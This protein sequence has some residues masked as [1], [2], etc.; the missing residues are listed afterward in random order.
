MGLVEGQDRSFDAGGAEEAAGGP[1]D[2]AGVKE[3]G[4][5]ENFSGLVLLRPVAGG[6][7]VFVGAGAGA[8][9]SGDRVGGDAFGGEHGGHEV[10]L[11]FLEFQ[12]DSDIGLDLDDEDVCGVAAIVKFGG[13]ER[14]PAEAAPED[15]DRVGILELVI[16]DPGAGQSGEERGAEIPGG[17]TASEAQENK[18]QKNLAAPA[19]FLWVIV[20]QGYRYGRTAAKCEVRGTRSNVRSNVKNEARNSRFGFSLFPL[21]SPVKKSFPAPRGTRARCRTWSLR[22]L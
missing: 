8:A 5:D 9:N 2:A 21:F 7:E 10:V 11:G 16:D 18:A 20:G 17:R 13:F 6:Q 22:S 4:R 15:E 1:G 12:V 3:I 19:A 14:A